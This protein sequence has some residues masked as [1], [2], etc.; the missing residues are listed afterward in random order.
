MIDLEREG[1]ENGVRQ[2]ERNGEIRLVEVKRTRYCCCKNQYRG[3]GEGSVIYQEKLLPGSKEKCTV[4]NNEKIECQI[5][6]QNKK[7]MKTLMQK[8]IQKLIE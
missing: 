5:V 7:A 6:R 4:K 1:Q 2:N 8:E 3:K